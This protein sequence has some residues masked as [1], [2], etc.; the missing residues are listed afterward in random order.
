MFIGVAARSAAAFGHAAAAVAPVYWTHGGRLSESTA[1]IGSPCPG[2]FVGPARARIG[3]TAAGWALARCHGSGPAPAL[4]GSD[5]VRGGFTTARPAWARPGP[6]GPGLPPPAPRGDTFQ[7]ATLRQALSPPAGAGRLR[8]GRRPALSTRGLCAGVDF[9]APAAGS[10]APHSAVV[11]VACHSSRRRADCEGDRLI[12]AKEGEDGT[13][14]KV[15]DRCL[16]EQRMQQQ[17]GRNTKGA[18]EFLCKWWDKGR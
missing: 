9:R 13:A 6:R 18:N 4:S 15:G 2:C 5:R 17:R 16:Q 12:F 3:R 10:D 14:K 7:T 11:T 1:G 8:D